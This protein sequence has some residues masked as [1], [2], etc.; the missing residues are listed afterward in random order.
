MCV[1]FVTACFIG[2]QPQRPLLPLRREIGLFVLCDGLLLL[3]PQLLLLLLPLLLPR[4]LLLP[5]CLLCGW[6]ADIRLPV[7]HGYCYC[8][9]GWCADIRFPVRHGY[10]YCYS[11]CFVAGVLIFGFP[12]DQVLRRWGRAWKI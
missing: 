3:L 11:A 2:L 7:R 12:C 8:H 9:S 1:S 10:C 6:C 5:F 4:L